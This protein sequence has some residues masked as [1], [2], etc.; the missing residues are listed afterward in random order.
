[1]TCSSAVGAGQVAGSSQTNLAPCRSAGP[2]GAPSARAGANQKWR[3]LRSRMSRATGV[4]ARACGEPGGVVAGVEEHQGDLPALGRRPRGHEGLEL[5]DRDGGGLLLR[6]HPAD[7]HGRRPAVAVPA[8][9]GQPLVRPPGHDGVAAV[10]PAGGVVLV[11]PLRAG[12]GPG[13]GPDAHVHGVERRPRRHGLAHQQGPERLDGMW[14][15][16]RAAYTLPHPRRWPGARLRCGSDG[17]APAVS[18]ASSTSSSASRRRPK[19]T[20]SPAR[21]ARSAYASSSATAG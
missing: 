19:H 14:P 5:L 21:N 1:M 20:N 18:T 8:E 11:P 6:P 16:R 15:R 17:T 10:P 7:V 3:L 13:P 2:G 12:G 4:P 9:P